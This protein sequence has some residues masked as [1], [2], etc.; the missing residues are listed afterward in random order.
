MSPNAFHSSLAGHRAVKT[1]IHQAQYPK[2]VK[3]EDRTIMSSCAVS[4]GT[5]SDTVAAAYI[6]IFVRKNGLSSG[7]N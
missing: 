7:D 6:V 2:L 5:E 1:L 3:Q 4:I